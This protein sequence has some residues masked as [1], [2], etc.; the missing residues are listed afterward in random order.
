VV[1]DMVNEMTDV[2]E[3][4]VLVVGGGPAGTWAA[5]E[6][7]RTGAS[8][9]LADKGRCGQSGATAAAGTA[10]WSVPPDPAAREE[11]MGAREAMGGYLAERSWMSR[12]LDETWRRVPELDDWGYPFPVDED[13]TPQRTS[14][15]GPDYMKRQRR[16][17]RQGGAVILD[18]HPVL[19]LLTDGDGTVVGAAGIRRQGGDGAWRVRAKAVVLASGGC[20]FLSRSLG[21]DVDT[22]DGLLF[23]VE[24]GAD[25]SGMEFSNSY[26][27][28]PAGTSMTKSSFYRFASFSHADG[29][30]LE[31]AG[32][33]QRSPIARALD[34]EPV[35]AQLDLLEPA[36][37]PLLRRIQPNFF[38]T[39]DRLGLDPFTQRFEIS[40]V[41][42]GTVRGTGGIRLTGPGCATAVPGL[43]AAG[44]VATREMVCGGFTGGGSHNA[45]WALSSG[46]WAGAAAADFASDLGPLAHHRAAVAVGGAGLRPTDQPSGTA[47]RG[48]TAGGTTAGAVAG[49]AVAGAV[50]AR[51][52]V[53][54]VQAE[55]MPYGRNYFRS[56]DRL[57]DSLDRLD[58]AW[59]AT[60]A[61]LG[62]GLPAGL[63]ARAQARSREAAAMLAT[64]RWMYR[65]AAARTETRGMHKREDFPAGDAGQHHRLTTGG[66]DQ[67]WVRPAPLPAAVPA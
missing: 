18:H 28:A 4:D 55:V 6:A 35:F 20:A 17:V 50:S 13:G 65:S 51:D 2:L 33:Y 15:Q 49:G 38:E 58:D 42:E 43:Y 32:G 8:V 31:G 7:L 23:A 25:L 3:T 27:I 16:R 46:C 30:P 52:V 39:F 22:G 60:R 24:A 26:S 67:V 41:L 19:E 9:V 40:L 61:H 12:V 1:E 64:A 53:A 29:S 34:H 36:Y 5:I 44:D 10:I 45:A 59:Q 63:D 14:L 66:L 62:G 47:T 11:A 37:R 54:A 57:A 56:G 48:T 21:T